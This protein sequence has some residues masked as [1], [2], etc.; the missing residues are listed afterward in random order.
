MA[1]AIQLTIVMPCLNEAETLAGCIEKARVGIERAGMRG[2]HE[3]SFHS[4]SFWRADAH[5]RR[6]VGDRTAACD[7]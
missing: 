5:V 7:K 3:A 6:Q 4:H 1:L 2:E